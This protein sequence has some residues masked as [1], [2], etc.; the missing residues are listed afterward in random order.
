MENNSR[1]ITIRILF[2]FLLVAIFFGGMG[3]L[4]FKLSDS[5]KSVC[6]QEVTATCIDFEMSYSTKGTDNRHK[7]PTYTPVFSYEYDGDEYVSWSNT[8]SSSF[9]RDFIIGN[10]YTIFIN[11]DSPKDFYNEVI[12]NQTKLLSYIFMIVGFVPS[13][14]ILFAI[15]V[16]IKAYNKEKDDFYTY[17]Q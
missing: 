5:K 6:N 2:A 10:E 14:F 7:S 8:Y 9:R 3:F 4:L 12:N 17:R 13:A 1:K 15:I 16:N 11:P